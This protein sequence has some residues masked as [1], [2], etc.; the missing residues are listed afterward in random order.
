MRLFG[1][2]AVF[3]V[4]IRDGERTI[5]CHAHW[6]RGGPQCEGH[7]RW[8]RE[9]PQRKPH[10]RWGRGGLT[11]TTHHY[12]GPAGGRGGPSPVGPRCLGP[13][14]GRGCSNPATGPP[15]T[16]TPEEEVSQGPTVAVPSEGRGCLV[17]VDDK[18]PTDEG[19]VPPLVSFLPI[20]FSQKC[21][22]FFSPFFLIN[23]I[24]L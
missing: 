10:A 4:D 21:R 16:V 2:I 8:E 20:F 18:G 1:Y 24:N 11:I 19:T 6:G 17:T 22:R 5:W 9:G 23:M 15:V 14:K 3:A 12:C 7:A 13:A